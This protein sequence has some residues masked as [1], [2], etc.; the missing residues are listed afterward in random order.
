[1][2]GWLLDKVPLWLWLLLAAVALDDGW[3]QLRDGAFV[4]KSR[5]V[6]VDPVAHDRDRERR[7]WEG[8]V[9]LLECAGAPRPP[10][11]RVSRP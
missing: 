3:A 9:E 7:L 10:V 4:V 11:R 5:V 8:T 2:I 6:D 1:M